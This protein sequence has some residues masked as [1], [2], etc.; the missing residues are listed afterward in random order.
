MKIDKVTINGLRIFSFESKEKILNYIDKNK[1]ILVAVNA[2]KIVNADENLRSMINS[3]VGYCDGI[4]AVLALKKL[5]HKSL[6]IPGFHLWIDIIKKFEN[7][8]SFYFIGGTEKVIN[9]TIKKIKHNFPNIEIKNFHSG[10]FDKE[11][12]KNIS[13]DI[14]NKKPDVVFIAMGSPKQE[15]LMQKLYNTHPAIY[16]GLGG[17][18]DVYVN[19]VKSP[20]GFWMDYGLMWFIRIIREPKKRLKRMP[21]LVKFLIMLIRLKKKY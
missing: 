6:Q 14:L 18:F 11:Q 7:K 15:L 16:Q 5:G 2:E 13:K 3:H 1:N 10:F 8:K 21:T 4:G 12:E 20:D 19:K 17:S 9:L